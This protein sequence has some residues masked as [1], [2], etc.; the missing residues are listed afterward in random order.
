[1]KFESLQRDY[2]EEVENKKKGCSLPAAPCELMLT[3][4]FPDEADFNF[5]IGENKKGMFW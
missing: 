4:C 5:L 1:M 3:I 2:D